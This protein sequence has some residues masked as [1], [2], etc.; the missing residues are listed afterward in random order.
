MLTNFFSYLIQ[1]S[2]M[3][4]VFAL[5]YRLFFRHLTH[6]YWNRAYLLASVV[7]SSLLPLL[8]TVGLFST[9]ASAGLALPFNPVFFGSGGAVIPALTNAAQPLGDAIQIEYLLLGVYGAGFLYKSWRFCRNLWAIFRLSRAN[10][11]VEDGPLY[12]VYFQA[13]LPTFSFGHSIFLRSDDDSLTLEEQA[14]VLLHEEIHVRHRHTLDL[15]LFELAGIVFWF[16]PVVYYLRSCLR[17]VHEYTVDAV[18]TRACGNVKQYGYLLLKMASETALPLLA[19]FSNKQIFHRIQMLTQKPSTSMQKLNYLIV[20][21]L[22]AL[23]M[24]I[25]SCFRNDDR[26]AFA[27]RSVKPQTGLPIGQIT[28]Q[29]NRVYTTDELTKTLGVQRGDLYDKETFRDRLFNRLGTDVASLYMDKGYLFFNVDVRENRVSNGVNLELQVFEGTPVNIGAVTFKGNHKIP[30]E[31]LAKAV[32][33]RSGD[34]FNRSKLIQSQQTLA[35]S[36]YFDSKAIGI[37][38]VPDAERGTVDLEFTVIEK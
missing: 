28:W 5:A 21:P 22:L 35:E 16:N 24:M 20:L 10:Q 38:P 26:P 9:T 34:L 11:K 29:G 33:V 8:P 7:L 4:A 15:L 25:V 32:S 31:Q 12:S 19:T 23:S 14:Q 18:V 2:A 13:D 3:L 6:F 1:V 17:L 36:G 30:N 37:N 27:D